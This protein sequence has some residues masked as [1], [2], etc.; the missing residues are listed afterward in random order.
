MTKH[1][2]TVEA[3]RYRVVCQNCPWFVVRIGLK[4][5]EL[6]DIGKGHEYHP[7]DDK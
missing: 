4:P 5:D 1:K 2:T 7:G 6:R 3:D